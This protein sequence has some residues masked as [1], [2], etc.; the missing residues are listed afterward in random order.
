MT[1]KPSKAMTDRSGMKK[2]KL[3]E[4]L[5]I[6]GLT[7]KNRIFVS[8][9][10]QYSSI[11]GSATDWHLVHLGARAVGGAACVMVE[12]S[13]IEPEGRISPDDSGIWSDEHVQPFKRINRF[14]ADQN[15]VPAIQ[16]AHAG[17]KAATLPPWKGRGVLKEDNGGWKVKGPSEKPFDENHQVPHELTKEEIEALVE[18]FAQAAKRSVEAGFELI[19]IHSAHGYLLHSFL[20]P[21]SNKREDEY[22]GSLENR[23]SFVRQVVSAVRKVIPDE[24]PLFLR[25]SATD[26]VDGGWDIDESVELAK[27][28]KELGVDLIDCSSGALVPYA[29]I[30]QSP[31]YQVQFADR[32]KKEAKILTGAVGLITEASQAEAILENQLADIVLLARQMLIDPYWPLHAAQELSADLK[33][34]VQYE[35]GQELFKRQSD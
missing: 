34:P 3:F 24:M 19:E 5:T 31:G 21:L 2:C 20:S 10:C 29:K 1:R 14:I 22:G 9:M 27:M 35:R 28:V 12:A 13:A 23:T 8:P 25:I 16:L 33:W 18:K 7:L 4:P 6:R 26:W 11:D 17:R 32:I 15:C 30:P